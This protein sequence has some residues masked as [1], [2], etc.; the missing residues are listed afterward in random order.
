MSG[1]NHLEIEQSFQAARQAA[2]EETLQALLQLEEKH[3]AAEQSARKVQGQDAPQVQQQEVRQEQVQPPQDQEP[4]AQPS[5]SIQPL[6]IQTPGLGQQDMPH[7]RGG[8][9]SDDGFCCGCWPAD[10]CFCIIQ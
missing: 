4:T 5:V 2:R 7:L 9:V 1:E 3:Q 6:Q 10:A 8:C